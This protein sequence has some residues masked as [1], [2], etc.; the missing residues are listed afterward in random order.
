MRSRFTPLAMAAAL[1]LLFAATAAVA[2]GQ[3]PKLPLESL[4]AIEAK[5]DKVVDISIDEGMLHLA[6]RFLEKDANQDPDDKRVLEFLQGIKGVYVREFEF[7]SDGVITPADLQA[8]RAKVSQPGW[9]RLV[10]VVSKKAGENAEVYVLTQGDTVLGLAVIASEPRK[11]TV[12][13][14]VGSIDVT[15]LG[16]LDGEFGVPRIELKRDKTGN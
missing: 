1:A 3:D 9:S 2:Y 5:A 16:D 12:V 13:S 7:A 11:L 15:K 6:R 14:I 8:I 4:G 10:G